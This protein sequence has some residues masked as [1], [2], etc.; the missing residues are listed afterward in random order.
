LV[1]EDNELVLR[2]LKRALVQRFEATFA[3]SG[4]AALAEI[5]EHDFD[6]VVSDV[7]MRGIDGRQVLA[8]V[9]EI[10]PKATRILLTASPD[11]R[12]LAVADSVIA[13]PCSVE[14]L[15]ETIK[16]LGRAVG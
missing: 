5:A 16:K 14:H 7:F 10:R 11:A 3:A 8:A 15:V 13:K 6:A 1:V 2:A 9:R 12:E 4:E